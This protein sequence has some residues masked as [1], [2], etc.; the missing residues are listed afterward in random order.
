MASANTNIHLADGM[1]SEGNGF[2]DDGLY[3][4]INTPPAA[5]LLVPT[6]PSC[7]EALGIA[8]ID[9]SMATNQN[10]RLNK[11]HPQNISESHLTNSCKRR[12][13]PVLPLMSVHR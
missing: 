8:S 12:K 10:L 13:L 2:H 1:A 6:S 5:S 11:M 4:N 7:E 9:S 3:R